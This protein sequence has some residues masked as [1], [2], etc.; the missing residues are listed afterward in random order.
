MN[1]TETL[2]PWTRWKLNKRQRYAAQ[3]YVNYN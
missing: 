1:I 2:S 3:A